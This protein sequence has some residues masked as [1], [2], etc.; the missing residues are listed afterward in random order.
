MQSIM[1]RK[2]TKMIKKNNNPLVSV[3]IPSYNSS[4]FIKDTLDS[5]VKQTYKNLEIVV[6]DDAS[7]DDTLN[8]VKKYKDKDSRIEI[9]HREINLGITLNMNDAIKRCKGNILL[10]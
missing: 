7:S 8:I 5:V 10:F 1:S 4:K 6:S 9:I 2:L 3:L